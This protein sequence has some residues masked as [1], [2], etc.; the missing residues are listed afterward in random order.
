MTTVSTKANTKIF[1]IATSTCANCPD[2]DI[3][4]KMPK[5]CSGRNGTMA[6]MITSITS[7]RNS[8]KTCIIFSARTADIPK[9]STKARISAVV[10]PKTGGMVN[11]LS[12]IE[13]TAFSGVARS[14]TF[15]PL[16]REG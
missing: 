10:T 1:A 2:F 14:G 9:P 15:C 4:R 8:R 6:F 5:M 3:F 11:D 16:R 12:M 13:A 7:S